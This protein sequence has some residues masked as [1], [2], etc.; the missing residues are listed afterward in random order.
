[1]ESGVKGGLTFIVFPY[2]MFAFYLG[3][4]VMFL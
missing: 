4:R 3:A 1:M 2:V